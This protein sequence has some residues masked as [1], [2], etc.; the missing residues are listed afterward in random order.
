[1]EPVK[2]T[3]IKVLSELMDTPARVKEQARARREAFAELAN[4]IELPEGP[5]APAYVFYGTAKTT[6]ADPRYHGP[7]QL[8]RVDLIVGPLLG[9]KGKRDDQ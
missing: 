7:A 8:Y 6:P 2:V 5:D 9:A 3:V 4:H 1:M